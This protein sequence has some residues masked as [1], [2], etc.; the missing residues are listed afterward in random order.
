MGKA[1]GVRNDEDHVRCR[2]KPALKTVRALALVGV[3]GVA[4]I[5]AGAYLRDA[6][7]WI[8]GSET[9]SSEEPP[10]QA[11]LVSDFSGFAGSEFNARRLVAGLLQGN[12]ITLVA[13]AAG[14]RPGATTRFTPPTRPMDYSSIHVALL[15]AR[16]QL[17]RLGIARPTPAQ[18]KAVLAGGG[19]AGRVED[20]AST[21]VLLPGL[22]QMRA[23][24]MSWAR[25]ADT[26]GVTLALPLNGGYAAVAPVPMNSVPAAAAHGSRAAVPAAAGADAQAPW[27]ASMS[28]AAPISSAS[29]TTSAGGGPTSRAEISRPQPAPR[30]ARAG[31]AREPLRSKSQ[32]IAAGEDAAKKETATLH[33]PDGT[34]GAPV[35]TPAAAT[36]AADA[37]A[38]EPAPS[39]N[40][41]LVN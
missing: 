23:G 27:S 13:R 6:A 3:L 4:T 35:R 8:A 17:A 2:G 26:M 37:V 38:A 12:E 7:T 33:S 5:A 14:G 1:R 9:V 40:G 39:A 20:R 21:P 11:R 25:I 22:L 18:I 31:R 41:R 29:I 15:L 34:Q 36:S 10:A 16:E 32:V 30:T 24:G 28:G 19:V